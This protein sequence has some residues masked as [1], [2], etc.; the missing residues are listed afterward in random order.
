MR[1]PPE[2]NLYL[3][4]LNLSLIPRE[5]TSSKFP[6]K[7]QEPVPWNST[8]HRFHFGMCILGQIK[9]CKLEFSECF[10]PNS[11]GYTGC[12]ASAL[13]EKRMFSWLPTFIIYHIKQIT[14]HHLAHWLPQSCL[15]ADEPTCQ[16]TWELVYERASCLRHRPQELPAIKKHHP[17]LSSTRTVRQSTETVCQPE[18]TLPTP[19]SIHSLLHFISYS[20]C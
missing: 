20:T 15:T 14:V 18:K 12:K 10:T 6:L 3:Q 8:L 5:Q 13:Q 11:W 1:A 4:W 2:G 19:K 9:R 16:T 7:Y 17:K